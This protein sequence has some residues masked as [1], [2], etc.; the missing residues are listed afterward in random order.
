MTKSQKIW[1]NLVIWGG[2]L[3]VALLFWFLKL[4]KTELETEDMQAV[5]SQVPVV[6]A[7]QAR[8]GN[9]QH[10]LRLTGTLRP[11]D[12]AIIRAEVD[13]RIKKIHFQE[14]SF[15]DKKDLLI[16][17][18]SSRAK[19]SLREAKAKLQ[20]A[21][22]EYE[23]TQKLAAEQIISSSECDR[24]RSEME[25][26]RAQVD[27]QEVMLKKHN[28]R[29]PF[30][31]IIG[32][33]EISKG[34]FVNAGKEL[35]VLVDCTPLKIDFKVPEMSL[36][37]VY[38]GQTVHVFPNELEQ[39]F[40]AKIIAIDPIGDSSAHSFVAR[41]VLE[42]QSASMRP[43]GFAEV[44][45][46]IEEGEQSILVPESAI[47]RRGDMDIVY[48]IIDGIVIRSP[49]ITGERKN[50]EVE[51]LSGVDEGDY[52][53][54]AG[55]MKVRDNKPVLIQESV[56]Q[57]SPNKQKEPAASST[58]GTS[59]KKETGVAEKAKDK[60]SEE[61]QIANAEEKASVPQEEG[62]VKRFVHSLKT[63]F[64]KDKVSEEGQVANAEEKASVPQEEGFVKRFVHF[65][66]TLFH[67]DNQSSEESGQKQF[68]D[69]NTDQSAPVQ[70]EDTSTASVEP[71]AL[72]IEEA[73]GKREGETSE[74]TFSEISEGAL[75]SEKQ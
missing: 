1:R 4:R 43:G 15:V 67:K 35:V 19:A 7:V 72:S 54:T 25:A 61:G 42:N 70:G 38:V 55:H 53:V 56:M 6:E 59:E 28:I 69:K 39:K 2:I 8:L 65:L 62:F 30:D 41:A 5:F 12:R 32:L 45:V 66:K 21:E 57:T 23:R 50:G 74:D 64:H 60:V 37:H 31:G 44:Y 40:F 10:T 63:L 26:L 29:A 14:G 16:E 13:G 75:Q 48:R 24:R 49:V 20:H 68:K 52:V 71:P 58:K 73:S 47:E 51:I 33:K 27:F 36:R 9:M 18:D 46:P 17:L 34:E 3:V 11:N 22:S